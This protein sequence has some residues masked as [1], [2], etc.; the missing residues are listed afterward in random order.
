MAASEDRFE[1]LVLVVPPQVL[2]DL[3][4]RVVQRLAGA[5]PPDVEPWVGVEAVARH[6]G[7]R[8]Q[9]ICD[10]VSRRGR[11]GIPR[12]VVTR[13]CSATSSPCGQPYHSQC[14]GMLRNGA[15]RQER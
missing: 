7:C 9:R 8:R 12:R 14:T 11:G 3:V 13:V 10:L 5:R 4:K 1:G 6:L 2:D 15:F